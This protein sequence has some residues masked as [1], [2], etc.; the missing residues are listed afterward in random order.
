MIS[1]DVTTA[2]GVL[3]GATQTIVL[4]FYFLANSD[5]V[6]TRTR[7]G[8]ITTLT[9]DSDYSVLGAG[10]ESGGS[11]TVTGQEAGDVITVVRTV[12][13][14]QLVDLVPLTRL[15]STLLEQA[16]DKLTMIGQQL[17]RAVDASG[18]LPT[19]TASTSLGVDSSGNWVQRSASDLFTFLKTFAGL[20][21]TTAGTI[22]EGNDARLSNNRNPTAHAASHAAAGSDPVT[23]A[24]IG[25]ATAAELDDLSEV[26]AAIQTQLGGDSIIASEAISATAPFV[27]IY[28]NGGV[29]TCR[30]ANATN[31]TKPVCGFVTTSVSSGGMAIIYNV[32]IITGLSGLTGGLVYLSTTNGTATN[33]P[34]STAGNIIQPLGTAISATTIRVNIS[35]FE[36]V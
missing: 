6:V 19:R 25:A 20:F 23:P 2:T 15:S 13:I 8:T 22:T 27:N 1:T 28:N 14:T 29:V 17:K 36:G 32:G 3:T 35:S 7:A 18:L 12:P 21:G 9:L 16:L 5:L 30:N 4:G 31:A 26:T 24:A 10:N 33:T 34:P 11:I